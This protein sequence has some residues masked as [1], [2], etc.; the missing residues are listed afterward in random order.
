MVTTNAST[1]YNGTGMQEPVPIRCPVTRRLMIRVSRTGE[2]P[3]DLYLR[4]WCRGCH[5]EHEVGKQQI[6]EARVQ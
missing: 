2:W 3:N 4:V 6:E 5:T 1:P